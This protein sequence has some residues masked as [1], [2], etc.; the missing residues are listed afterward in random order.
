[1]KNITH[2][3]LNSRQRRVKTLHFFGVV[4]LLVLIASI[5]SEVFNHGLF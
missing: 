2:Q 4:A 5:S 3:Q 1:M